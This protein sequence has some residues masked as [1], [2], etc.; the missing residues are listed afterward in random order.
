MEATER[1]KAGGGCDLISRLCEEEELGLNEKELCALLEP[2]KYTGRCERQ[3]EEYV[4]G[5]RAMIA[6]SG[7]M[8][9]DLEN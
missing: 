3:V 6:G 8:K 9:A 2:E 5:V 7:R 1:M 4:S